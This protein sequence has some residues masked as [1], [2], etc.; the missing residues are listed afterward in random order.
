MRIIY[1]AQI[2]NSD[3]LQQRTNSIKNRTL[4]GGNKFLSALCAGCSVSKIENEATA[5]LYTCEYVTD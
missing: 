3:E 1:Q 2:N 4:G 5:F